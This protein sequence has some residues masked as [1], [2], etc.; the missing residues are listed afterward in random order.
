[1]TSKKVYTDG[2]K[3]KS[4][5]SDDIL[6]SLEKTIGLAERARELSFR[7]HMSDEVSKVVNKAATDKNISTTFAGS[8]L[9]KIDRLQEVLRDTIQTLEEFV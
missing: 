5:V 4:V 2:P 3:A 9:S 7:V 1:M 8:A 6:E